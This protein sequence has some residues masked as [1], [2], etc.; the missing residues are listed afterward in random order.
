[1]SNSLTKNAGIQLH[2]SA[3]FAGVALVMAFQILFNL[4]T[5]C[6]VS[7]A[8]LPDIANG[9]LK[10]LGVGP[11]LWLGGSTII[12]MFSGGWL[13][14]K[15]SGL[16]KK[17][18][19][20]LHGLTVWAVVT[21]LTFFIVDSLFYVNPTLRTLDETVSLTDKAAEQKTAHELNIMQMTD[22]VIE[23]ANTTLQEELISSQ[24]INEQ[25]TDNRSLAPNRYFQ[26]KEKLNPMLEQLLLAN[27]TDQSD[28]NR[29]EIITRLVENTDM[30]PQKA[31]QKIQ[32]WLLNF[33]N[34]KEQEDQKYGEVT[35][36]LKEK[37]EQAHIIA[38]VVF[39][40]FLAGA[41]AAM[42]GGAWAK[43]DTHA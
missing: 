30:N 31:E 24:P 41:L 9:N 35:Q 28:S 2:W 33:N 18:S 15:Y 21:L 23:Q 29:Q 27:N 36:A 14:G 10:N 26:L 6:L 42:F 7:F 5:L 13:A 19:G 4:L 20:V 17:I 1:M 34:L 8:A 39:F 16:D 3:V 11:T 32:Q 38:L 40:T 25:S 43:K 12:A 22:K 37:T